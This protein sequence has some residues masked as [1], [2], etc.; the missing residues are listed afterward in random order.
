M[1]ENIILCPVCKNHLAINGKNAVCSNHHNYDLAKSGYLNLLLNH[2]QS[3]DNDVMINARHTFLSKGYFTP[4][5]DKIIALLQKYQIKSLLDVGCGEG[6][7][8]RQIYHAL[9]IDIVGV[10]ISKTACLKAA[11]NC[12][13]VFYI[14]ASNYHLPFSDQAFDGVIN[15]F[16][17]HSLELSRVAKKVIIKVVPNINHL[18]EL[19]DLLY[20]DVY[21]KDSNE[22]DFPPFVKTKEE[23]LTYQVMIDQLSDLIK[24]TPYYYKSKIDDAILTMTNISMTMDFKIIIYGQKS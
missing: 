9:N 12:K 16:A 18:R 19:K 24:M 7:Y 14:V 17:P 5:C 15:I 13:E 2:P 8:S 21:L 23:T 20:D 10:D 22:G 1:K 3:G 4:L 11:Q 6:Y